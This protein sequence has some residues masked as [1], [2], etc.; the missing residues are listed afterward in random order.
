M[1]LILRENGIDVDHSLN[2]K[3]C[4]KNTDQIPWGTSEDIH[5]NLGDTYSTSRDSDCTSRD[6]HGT[7]NGTSSGTHR[8][9]FTT[10]RG[11]RG[12]AGDFCGTRGNEGTSMDTGGTLR[13]SY[14]T[15]MDNN[16]VVDP[17]FVKTGGVLRDNFGTSGDRVGTSRD[18]SG[19][20]NSLHGD[21]NGF[22]GTQ[23]DVELWSNVENVMTS[24]ENEVKDKLETNGFFGEDLVEDEDGEE[25]QL[26]KVV[27]G[28]RRLSDVV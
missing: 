6:T 21:I 14:G 15:S 28:K 27:E 12:I 13:E 10:S 5:S 3:M 24:T 26:W 19:Y 17:N 25:G 7:N 23:Q 18:I 11:S 16:G 22:E 20:H 4:I 2:R 8:D 9:T 1:F